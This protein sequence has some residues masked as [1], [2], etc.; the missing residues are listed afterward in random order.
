M[1]QDWKKHILLIIL[2]KLQERDSGHH[3]ICENVLWDGVERAM[4][5]NQR[6]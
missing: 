3:K 5:K 1:F 2:T 6:S 4:K